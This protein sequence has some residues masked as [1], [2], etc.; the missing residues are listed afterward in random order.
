M[1]DSTYF[2][3]LAALLRER[4]EPQAR[5]E[6]LVGELA[7][8][9]EEAGAD[10]Y[11]EFGPVGELAAQLTERESA[12]PAD[13]PREPEDGAEA[14]VWTADAFQDQLLLEQFG[15]QG[16]E[17]ERL[18]KLGRFVCRRDLGH[19]MRWEYRRE[20]AGHLQRAVRTG[21]LGP[22]GW[23]QCGVWGPFTY[24]KRPAAVVE[25]PAA[26]LA[27]PPPPPQKRV[28]IGKWLYGWTAVCLLV[29]VLAAW[30]GAL[31][32]DLSEGSTLAGAVVGLAV[33]GGAAWALW[34]AALRKQ[35]QGGERQTTGGS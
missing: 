14:W 18:D 26:Q 11:E 19:P 3:T 17:V 32:V 6:S 7:A 20:T 10:A 15:A 23:E 2:E 31:G 30:R 1:T 13:G 24:Y 27:E 21:Q 16:W 9:A 35:T 4:G 22:E 34:R 28:Y 5:I 29:V 33:G 25:G 8:H 12:G